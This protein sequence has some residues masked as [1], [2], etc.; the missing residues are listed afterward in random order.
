[1]SEHTESEAPFYRV[2]STGDPG[3]CMHCQQA[4]EMWTIVFDNDGE[5]TEVGESWGHKETAEDICDLMNMAYDA[6][7]EALS[8][9][10]KLSGD[11]DV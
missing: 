7:R 5:P 4:C 6:G 8:D 3:E 10:N 1:M 11:H 2:E 9:E